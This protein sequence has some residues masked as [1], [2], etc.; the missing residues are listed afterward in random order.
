MAKEGVGERCEK[1]KN[2]LERRVIFHIPPPCYQMALPATMIVVFPMFL[3]SG[4]MLN[5]DDTPVYLI[6]FVCVC[7]CVC[8]C[9]RVRV[10]ARTC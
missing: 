1:Q 6:W 7:A 9:A 3:F 5:F 4:L 10:Y 2:K 8:V